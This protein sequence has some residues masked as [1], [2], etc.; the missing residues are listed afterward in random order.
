MDALVIGSEAAGN[1]W[2]YLCGS[3]SHAVAQLVYPHDHR[4]LSTVT[5][6]NMKM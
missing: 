1:V 3:I 6:H 2:E 4:H 5:G